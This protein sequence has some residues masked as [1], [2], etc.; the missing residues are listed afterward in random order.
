MRRLLSRHLYSAPHV[1]PHCT[2]LYCV[3]CTLE[4][5]DFSMK[6]SHAS[7]VAAAA[8][9]AAAATGNGAHAFVLS[10]PRVLTSRTTISTCSKTD[11]CLTPGDY[12]RGCSSRNTRGGEPLSIMHMGEGEGAGAVG[13]GDE[14]EARQW[15]SVAGERRT[16]RW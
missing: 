8:A 5:S 10:Q 16:S 15:E 4:L 1:C 3:H 7:M 13:G 12:T 14:E 6:P 9:V 2:F 11:T